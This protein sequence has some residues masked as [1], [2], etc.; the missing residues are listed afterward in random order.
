[1]AIEWQ[2]RASSDGAWWALQD[3]RISGEVVRYDD[4]AG[5]QFWAGFARTERIPGKFPTIDEAKAAVEDALTK[6][7]SRSIRQTHRR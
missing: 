1:V 7:P 3:R 2:S 5:G 6:P 4:P